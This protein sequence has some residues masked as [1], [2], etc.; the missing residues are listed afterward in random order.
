MRFKRFIYSVLLILFVLVVLGDLGLWFLVPEAQTLREDADAPFATWEG[1]GLPE[2]ADFAGD[3]SRPEGAAAGKD[4]GLP[5]ERTTSDGGETGEGEGTRRP[6]RTRSEGAAD[7]VEGTETE[8]TATWFSSLVTKLNAYLP[9]SELQPIQQAVAPYRLYILIGGALGMVLCIVRLAFLNRSIRRQEAENPT[10]SR[11]VALWPAALLLLGALVLVVLLFPVDKEEAA[12]GAVTNE[13]VLSGRVEEKTLTSLIQTAGSLEEQE[14]EELTVPASV[15]VASVC[16]HNGDAVTA[17]QI[18]AL[19]DRAS[20]MQAI[21]AVHEVLADMDGQLQAAHDTKGD[22]SLTAPVAGTVK[23]VYAQVG[24]RAMDVMQDHGSLMLLSLDGRMAVQIPAAEG[25]TIGSDLVVTLPDGVE[26]PGEVSFLEEGVAT[27]TVADQGYAIGAQVFVKT[28][29]GALLGSGPLYVHKALNIMGYLGT[30]THIYRSEGSLAY[31][32]QA[33]IGLADTADLTE[34]TALLQQRAEYE[35]ELKTLFELYQTGYIH[36][37]CDGV[38]EGLSED[39]AYVPLAQMVAGLT[40]RHLAASPADADA[41][42]FTNYLAQVTGRDG[43]TL[44]LEKV[45]QVDLTDYSALPAPSGAMEGS[46]TIPGSAPIY[47]LGGGWNQ[48]TAEDILPGDR[49]LFT[50]D[51]NGSLVW[52]IVAHTSTSATPTPVPTAT[53]APTA[54]PTPDAGSRDGAEGSPQPGEDGEASDGE[55]A[56]THGTGGRTGGRGGISFR[57]PSGSG[58]SA[59]AKKPAYTIAQQTLCTMTPQEKM[60]MVVAVDELDVLALSLGQEAE[61]YLDAFPATVFS[62]TVT[63][64]DTEGENSGGNTKYSVTLALD[65]QTQLYPG[66]NGTAC[67]PR[68]TGATVPTVPLVALEEEGNR[69]LIYTAYDEE[70]DALL[71]P[72]EVQTGLS[73]GTD[74]EIAAGLSPGDAYWYRYADAISYVTE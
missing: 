71:S 14:A 8:E 2:D 12:E 10:A 50:F 64:I 42:A 16:V 24:E 56:Q 31:A 22:T 59:A 28:V 48:I 25:L 17:G 15:T 32:N 73:D 61:L 49:V 52:V 46:Y 9:L 44:E 6:G 29:D 57:I 67:F 70:T 26:L 23:A 68:R 53:P 11:R 21:A 18:V 33:L 38:V 1:K 60:H 27:V 65:R 58:S 30:I 74:V 36:A 39:L 41:A 34:Y 69:I 19:A 4:G 20:V 5:R 63:K 3:G 37:P 45:G 40:V 54:T 13:R 7:T 55:D 66:M 62:A 51:S 43:N 35:G 72:V 47:R